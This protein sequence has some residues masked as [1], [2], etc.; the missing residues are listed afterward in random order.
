ML[1]NRP[2]SVDYI[3]SQYFGTLT[4]V[5][6]T[7]KGKTYQPHPLV[8][9]PLMFRDF[10]CPSGCGA[11]CNMVVYLPYIPL[12]SIAPEF[13]GEWVEVE[14]NGSKFRIFQDRQDDRT[15]THCRY[16]RTED[17]RCSLHRFQGE[18]R[19]QPLG[20]D[21]SYIATNIQEGVKPSRM[22]NRLP[23]R[24]SA[25]KRVTDGGRGG[26]CTMSNFSKDTIPELLRKL[27]R[28]KVWL[29]YFRLTETI[30]PELR[31]WI[32]TGPHSEPLFANQAFAPEHPMVVHLDIL[33]R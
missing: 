4:K 19:E 27:D 32:E 10:N 3:V 33:Q 29:E 31:H 6:F 30:E 20:C 23:G 24:L 15:L 25:R 8:V 9:S 21:I 26:L 18:G 12:E 14:F 16:L 2:D 5:P 11:C 28:V 17:G 22:I 1:I 13:R 7:Y